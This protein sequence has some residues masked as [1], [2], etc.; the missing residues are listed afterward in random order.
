LSPGFSVHDIVT[1]LDI[2]QKT[3][4]DCFN[5]VIKIPFPRMRNQLRIEYAMDQFK[6]DAHLKN[7]ISGIA[8]DAGFKNRA[9]F[10][11]AF[12]E[13]TKMT[14]VEWIN[15]NC[16]S[17]IKD[18]AVDMPHWKIEKTKIKAGQKQTLNFK[19]NR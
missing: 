5:Q 16:D 7:S 17:P 9:T 4:T 2:P 18:E 12:K 15:E 14:P 6:N 11:I 1:Q 19:D 3:V 13:V 8:T 10:Y